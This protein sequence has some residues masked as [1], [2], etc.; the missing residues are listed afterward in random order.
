[1][2]PKLM[3][4]LLSSEHPR[5]SELPT[6]TWLFPWIFCPAVGEFIPEKDIFP[7][8]GNIYSGENELDAAEAWGEVGNGGESSPAL[9]R[10]LGDLWEPGA[11]VA[12][13][14]RA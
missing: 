11:T 1:M 2:I 3:C 9:P 6:G 4:S 7:F 5:H 8:S 14:T 13:Q 10:A 12:E